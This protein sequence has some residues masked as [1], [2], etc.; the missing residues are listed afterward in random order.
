[1]SGRLGATHIGLPLNIQEADVAERDVYMDPGLGRYPLYRPSPAPDA[2]Q[3]AA[4]CLVESRHPVIVAGAGVLRAGAWT[5]LTALAEMLGCPVATS[6]SGKGAIAET[7]PYSLGVIGSNGGLG[8]R[9]D[10]IHGAN[11]VFF[12]GCHAGSVTTL[13]WTLPEDETKKMI[14]L[15]VD[16]NR[17]GVNYRVDIGIVGDAKPGIAA[18]ADAVADRL[19]GVSAGKTD[20]GRIAG[21]R[22][23][24]MASMGAFT[25]NAVPIRPERFVLELENALPEE[26]LVIAD[27][28]TPTPYL[29]A[30][31]RLPKAGRRFVAPRAH[32]A[33]GYA[34]PAVVGAC[35]AAPEKKVVGIMGD[36]SF[37]ISAGELETLFRLNLP[38]LLIVMTS[39]CFG[40]VKA[41]Q[42]AMG[43]SFFGVDFSMID[44]A[45]VARAFGIEGFRLGI[46]GFLVPF[47]FV[48]QPALLLKGTF[49][50]TAFVFTVTAI[51]VF[52][53]ACGVIGQFRRPLNWIQRCLF[54]AGAAL[55]VFPGKG[56]TAAGLILVGT[57][58]VWS[59]RERA[60]RPKK[61]RL[62]ESTIA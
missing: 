15:D 7:H 26:S 35:H 46:A 34:L 28:G 36:G 54:L 29:S 20:P 43:N 22:R 57:A 51:G 13:K 37:A 4:E 38:V 5:E 48:Y 44:H 17:I 47:A 19:A 62:S 3:H 49:L 30:Y 42:K 21:K 58:G 40:W 31:Y 52:C 27:P 61:E 24:F 25:S 32:G 23:A 10:F 55:L 39:A 59:W 33:L 60:G 45:A 50:E 11:L 9:H 56:T 12:I 2:V 53:L 1:M 14:Q 41:G 16:G 8:F 18:L 6:I